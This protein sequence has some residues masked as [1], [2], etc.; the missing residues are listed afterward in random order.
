MLLVTGEFPGWQGFDYDYDSASTV[1]S[2]GKLDQLAAAP[3]V[4]AS[5]AGL[6]HDS[7]L[8][9]PEKVLSSSVVKTRRRRAAPD[10]D[11]DS[12]AAIG[13]DRADRA[14]NSLEGVEE[15]D[16]D[17]GPCPPAPPPFSRPLLRVAD[18]LP[19]RGGGG[20]QPQYANYWAPLTHKRHTPPHPAPP[21]H[22]NDG[23]PRTRKRHPQE[24]RPQRLTE[25]SD[26]TQHAKGRTGDCPGPR[27]EPT[28]RRNVTRGEGGQRPKKGLC[29]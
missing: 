13:R 25:R 8:Q 19:P 22:T 12:I 17:H 26:P 7:D 20:G 2:R 23:A 4:V 14:S 11:C 15:S 27:K 21:R 16:T 5:S 9:K 1:L 10:I 3:Q 28:T 18:T 24:H 6:P 29:T